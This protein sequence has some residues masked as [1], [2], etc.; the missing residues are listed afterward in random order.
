MEYSG[1]VFQLRKTGWGSLNSIF[2]FYAD[3]AGS[4]ELGA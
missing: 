4:G 1:Y 3:N 2:I